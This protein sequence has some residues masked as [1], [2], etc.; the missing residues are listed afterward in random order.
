MGATTGRSRS[1]AVAVAFPVPV[2]LQA[3]PV[4]WP[5]RPTDRRIL[6]SVPV[7]A[8]ACGGAACAPKSQRSSTQHKAYT[9][10][11]KD[12]QN[13]SLRYVSNKKNKNKAQRKQNMSCQKNFGQESP[14]PVS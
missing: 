5:W 12:K 7:P 6:C 11:L 4:R 9:S 1:V 8:P 10:R 14:R 13:K 2:P 3:L